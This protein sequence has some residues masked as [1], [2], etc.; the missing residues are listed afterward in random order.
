MVDHEVNGYLARAFDEKDLAHGVKWI[1][2][3]ESRYISL[4]NAAR[5]K[6]LDEYSLEV[7]AKRYI[8]IYEEVMNHKKA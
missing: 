5:K 7:Q 2:E 4:S 8:D 1:M 3:D 6:A